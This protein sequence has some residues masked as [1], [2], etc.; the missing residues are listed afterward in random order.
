MAGYLRRTFY[1]LI[2]GTDEEDKPTIKHF[3]Q[4]YNIMNAV[5]NIAELWEEI[6]ESTV[7]GVWRKIWP[8]Y[9]QPETTPRVNENI[10]ALANY[11]GFEDIMEADVVDLLQSET[12]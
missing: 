1:Q 9:N 12:F 4:N 8:E 2:K 3:C 6:W 7:N 11:M 5:D 10:M